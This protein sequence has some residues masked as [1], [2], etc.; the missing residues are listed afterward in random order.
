MEERISTGLGVRRPEPDTLKLGDSNPEVGLG[1]IQ[2]VANF[3][4]GLGDSTSGNGGVLA[5]CMRMGG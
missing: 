3:D 5:H 2:F 1:L 4:E